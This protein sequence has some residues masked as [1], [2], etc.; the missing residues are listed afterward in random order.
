VRT[1]D[2]IMTTGVS[3]NFS[4]KLNHTGNVNQGHQDKCQLYVGKMH[5]NGTNHQ[6]IFISTNTLSKLTTLS[7][8]CWLLLLSA[9]PAL[10]SRSVHTH[11]SI[12]SRCQLMM[13]NLFRRVR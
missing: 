12:A 3:G 8:V 13:L 4:V 7:S 1:V 10:L 5:M 6:S 2:C 9:W 11:V